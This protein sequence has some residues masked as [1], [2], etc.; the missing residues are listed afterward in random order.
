MTTEVNNTILKGICLSQGMAMGK[1]FVYRDIFLIGDEFYNIEEGEIP[2]EMERIRRAIDEVVT[3]LRI[4]SDRVSI[5]VDSELGKIF[6][7]QELMLKSMTLEK[8]LLDELEKEQT[9]AER[10]VFRVFNRWQRIFSELPNPV[11][12]QKSEDMFDLCRRVINSLKGIHANS[13][14]NVPEGSILIAKRLLPSDTVFLSRKSIVGI[15][16]EEGGTAS[17]AAIITRELGIPSVGQVRNILKT[18]LQDDV[19]IIEAEKEQITINPDEEKI[20]EF[21]FR[22]SKRDCIIGHFRQNCRKEAVTK[23]GKRIRVLANI[24]CREDSFEAVEFGAEGIGLFRTENLYMTRRYVPCEEEIYQDMKDVLEPCRGMN[25][26]VR[27][28]DIGADKSLPFLKTVTES[29]PF[30]GLR[31]VRLLLAYPELMKSQ[32]N[33]ILQLRTDFDIGILIPM[34]TLASDVQ[35]VVSQLEICMELKG[36]SC[37]PEIGSMIETPAAALETESLASL[38]DFFSIGTNDLTQYTMAACRE[39]SLVS[40]YFIENHPAVLKLIELTVRTSRNKPVCICGE[41]AG[42]VNHIRA[43]L[44]LGVRSLSVSPNMIPM[45]K[46]KIREISL[47]D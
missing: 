20:N 10:I 47:C 32:I 11:I 21:L 37:R 45:V 16:V 23:C 33:A 24:G 1:A 38:V 41:M 26:T 27:L 2:D 35:E 12:Q 17:H 43:L 19:L 29:N 39:S 25:I 31:G 8:E 14:E 3:E 28:L 18:V 4:L 34:V 30:L 7:A 22:K 9:N 6:K 42:N 46:Q 5:E 36:V 40:K 15:V 44:S 13:L